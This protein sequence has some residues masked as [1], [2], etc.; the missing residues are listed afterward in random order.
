[1]IPIS[2]EQAPDDDYYVRSRGNHIHRSYHF[3]ATIKDSW[4]QSSS[5]NLEF[6]IAFGDPGFPLSGARDSGFQSKI[7]ARFQ[8]GSMRRRWNAKDNPRDN[9]IALF[10]GRDY[11]IEELTGDALNSFS[12]IWEV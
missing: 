5:L 7:V 4:S 3:P 2:A 12:L 11:G 9:D 6:P 10:L 1:M 8:I